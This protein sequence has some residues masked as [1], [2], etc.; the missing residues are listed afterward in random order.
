MVLYGCFLSFSLSLFL[1]LRPLDAFGFLH[2]SS[3]STC[4]V[5]QH[6]ILSDSTLSGGL[7]KTRQQL[8]G[9]PIGRRVPPACL[10]RCVVGWGI[11]RT[12]PSTTMGGGGQWTRARGEGDCRTRA[13]P[14]LWGGL[15]LLL[16]STTTSSVFRVGSATVGEGGAVGRV[17]W[18]RQTGGG[19]S[20][21]RRRRRPATAPSRRS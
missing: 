1:L 20:A 13:A 10:R 14:F 12:S 2:A 19:P 17:G 15:L 5:L 9:K 8:Q 4:V 6:F 3:T 18:A 21:A 11:L 16:L 7:T